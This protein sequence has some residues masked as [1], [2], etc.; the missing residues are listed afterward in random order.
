MAGNALRQMQAEGLLRRQ[1][2][3]TAQTSIAHNDGV[4]GSAQIVLWLPAKSQ[5]LFCVTKQIFYFLF[6]CIEYILYICI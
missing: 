2:I 5:H 1:D 3:L 6:Y 4:A